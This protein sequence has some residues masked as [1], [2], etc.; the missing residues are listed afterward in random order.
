MPFPLGTVLSA[1]P[2]IISAAADIIRAIR[3]HKGG[4]KAPAAEKLAELEDLFERQA[5]IIEELA[6]SN[7]NLALAARNN[8]MISAVSLLLAAAALMF[9]VWR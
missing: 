2:G 5:G 8:R 7:R 4:A 9:A 6:Q 3:E 1:T